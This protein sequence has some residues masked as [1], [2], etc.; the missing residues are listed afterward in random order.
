MDKESLPATVTEPSL[1]ITRR[2][3]LKLTAVTSGLIAAGCRPNWLVDREAAVPTWSASASSRVALLL[4]DRYERVVIK[5]KVQ[6]LLE[7]AGGL[8]EVVQP[9]SKVALKVNLTGG[10][11]FQPPSGYTAAE[12]YVTHPEVVRALG[13]L[14]IDA[15]ASQLLV[16]EGL[17]DR[18]SPS[19]WGYDP[20]ISELGAKLIDLNSPDPFLDFV[21]IPT[22]S[23]WL[24]Y[25]SF[26]LHPI[27]QEVDALISVAK[28]K[29]HYNCGITLSMKNLIGL[30]PVSRYRLEE[31]HW[32]RSA[33]HGEANQTRRR[34][35]RVIL[36]LN[37]A[38]RVDLALVDGIMTAEGG[39]APRGSFKPVQPGL[40]AAGRDPVA[41]DAV[42]T[43]A[44]GFDPLAEPPE[45]P[46]LRGD[47]YLSLAHELRL[48]SNRLSEI[49][50]V[51]AALEE[52]QTNFSPA[53]EI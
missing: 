24:V 39:E 40:L 14:L 47:N 41:V 9:G 21:K 18:E 43:A 25:E 7:A 23:G 52:V 8:G 51:G 42:M 22:G 31:S 29:C 13:E 11:R 30:V 53:W 6:A 44:M 46:F 12:S 49:E 3:F 19:T 37:R 5:E 36:D 28:M 50:V 48:G 27:L 17:Y 45:P 38:V 35:P 33:L 26:W 4:A 15:G 20:V 10:L 16:I 32:W 1:G 34:L 2:D